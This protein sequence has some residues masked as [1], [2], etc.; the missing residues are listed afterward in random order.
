VIEIPQI[1][2]GGGIL[3]PSIFARIDLSK[4]SSGLSEAENFFV[5]AEGGVSKR[6]GTQFITKIPNAEQTRLIPFKFNEEQTYVL[7]FTNQRIRIYRNGGLLLKPPASFF[8]FNDTTSG[9]YIHRTL[10]TNAHQLTTND[11]G[12]QVFI[13]NVNWN[14]GISGD[15]FDIVEVPNSTSITIKLLSYQKTKWNLSNMIGDFSPAVLIS[16]PFTSSEL[17]DIKYKQSNDVLYLTHHNYAPRKLSRLSTTE[18]SIN[19]MDFKPDHSF[20]ENLAVS[21]TKTGTTKYKYKVTAVNS[22]TQEES[23]VGINSISVGISSKSTTNPVVITTSTNHSLDTGDEILISNSNDILNNRRFIVGSITSNTL[24]LQ[25]ENGID[26][27]ITNNGN[28]VAAHCTVNNG[29]AD[30][31]KNV[32]T[33]NQ[34][35]NSSHYNIYKED[36]G[37][38]GFIGSTETTEF[39]DD[40]I[41]ADLDDTSPKLKQPFLLE[42]NYPSVVALHEQRSVWANTTNNPLNIWLSQTSQFENM[43]VSSPTKDTDAI[44]LKM[45]TGEGNEIRHIRSFSDRLM[46]FTSGSLWSLRP[47][48]DVDAITPTSKKLTVEDYIPCTNIEPIIIKNNILMVSGT[49]KS[50]FEIH[51]LGYKLETNAYSGSDLTVLSRHLFENNTIIDWA[52]AHSPNRLVVCVRDDGK[53]LVLSFLNE[54]QIYAWTEWQLNG[55]VESVCS[56][57]EGVYDS[58]YCV[59]N[60]TVNGENVRYIEKLDFN[61]DNY[62]DSH[63]FLQTETPINTV[64][65]LDHLN[66]E[67]VVVVVDDSIELV[68]VSNGSVTT[69]A[70]GNKFVIG[71][72][73]DAYISSLPL[74]IG[75]QTLSRKKI[76]KTISVRFQN[77]RGIFVGTSLNKMEELASREADGTIS[78]IDGTIKLP[79]SGDWGRDAKIYIKSEQ[80]FLMKIL[81]FIPTMEIA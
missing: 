75:T 80:G 21:T 45:V 69:T 74:N 48:G 23:L 37:L 19:V 5:H 50:G 34:V 78:V 53:L 6:P 72:G 79:I 81:N 51:S 40:H 4:F 49:G 38:Y 60:K 46:L 26:S 30:E 66:N 9:G 58:I 52:Y 2:F 20:P 27:N 11:V 73:Y 1:S 10:N 18:W 33:F 77:S 61:N 63:L 22:D 39:T 67:Q 65:G 17:A 25:D 31:P 44:S 13:N 55:N 15:Y 68:T 42:N 36:N 14:L 3:S 16:S 59:I 29:H 7:E 54:Q 41:A 8:S 28:I 12:S 47:G 76:I 24:E 43:N 71:K 35:N 62:L 56:I 64:Y 70:S 57:Q 32:I